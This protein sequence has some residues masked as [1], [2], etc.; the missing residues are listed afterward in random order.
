MAT[1][2]LKFRPSSVP[3][4]EGTLYYQVIHKRKV[5]WISTEHHIYA[6]EWDENTETIVVAARSERKGAL[7]L[8]QCKIDWALKRWQTILDRLE[9]SRKDYTVEELCETFSK[10][11]TYKT[12][13]VFLQ[14]QVTKKEQMKRQGTA[15]TYGN[16]YRRFKAFREDVDLTFDELTPDM[17]ECYEAWLIDKRLKQNSIRCYL[18]TLNTLLCKAVEEGM[19]NNTNLFSHVRLSYVKTTKRAI[20]EKELKVIANLELPE[21]STMALARDIFMFSFYMR[22]MPF[23]DIAYLRKT[24][25]KNGMCTY[26]RKKTNQCLMVEWEKAQQKI[27]DRYAHQM[28]NR[29]YLLPIIKEEDGTEYKQYQRMQININR[30]LKKIGE[31]AELKMPLTTYVARHTWASVARDMNIPI[32]VISEGMGHNSIKT[33]QVYLNSIDISRINEANKRIIKRIGG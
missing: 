17:I 29:S 22:G 23:V 5:K 33:T 21:N 27:L 14:E 18:R 25:L 28:E 30:A 16:A 20:S 31:M 13:F 15:R 11:Q 6:D 1:I 7:A 3:K 32:A 8:M 2:K 19:L 10:E 4:T 26:C 24:D 9:R 12:V